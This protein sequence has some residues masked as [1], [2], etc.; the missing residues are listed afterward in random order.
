MSEKAPKAGVFGHPPP[1]L[2]DIPKGATQLSPLVP[3][4]SPLAALSEGSLSEIVM[5][6][7]PG[8]LERRRAL[9]LAL[10]A[11]RPG[12]RLTALAPKDK[13]GARIAKELA[14]FGCA[15]DEGVKR[16][17]RIATCERPEKL[18][19][20]TL[21]KAEGAM[22]LIEETG[23][24][25]QPGIFSWDRIDPG[26]E[27]L[28]EH[29]PSLSGS[30][31]DLGCGYGF[32][33]R[34]LLA[35]SPAVTSLALV[36]IDG[37][38]VEAARHNVTDARATFLWADVRKPDIAGLPK[39]LDFVVMNAPFHD[40]GTEDRRLMTTF[41]ERAAAL[42]KNGG[43]CWL[44]ANRHLPYEAAMAPLFASITPVADARGFK[45]FEAKVERQPVATG[46]SK[47][48]G[49]KSARDDRRA[50]RKAEKSYLSDEGDF[51][52]DAFL[53]DE[54]LDPKTKREKAKPAPSKAK[55]TKPTPSKPQRRR[56]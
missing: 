20:L 17:H 45:V 29:L 50:T 5:F 28:I 34:H 14:E 41:L 55:P 13:G 40:G 15:V 46:R 48:S 12:G 35:K 25:S 49:P 30:G 3:G 47:K 6:A 23:F 37:R 43:V 53:E 9:A 18:P 22:R 19:D 31:A 24:W 26:S 44:V 39:G 7:Q 51:D 8:T 33:A 56:S 38:A 54:G 42:L 10:T 11:L 4:A 16:H 1:D 2:V 52:L 27:L 36:D 21:A 32:L